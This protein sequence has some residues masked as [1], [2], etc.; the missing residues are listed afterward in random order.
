MVAIS[1][2]TFPTRGPFL[3]DPIVS[4]VKSGKDKKLVYIQGQK[5]A[6]PPLNPQNE[7]V[8][9]LSD[10]STSGCAFLNYPNNNSVNAT[11]NIAH[12]NNGKIR[13]G[14]YRSIYADK[15][16]KEEQKNREPISNGIYGLPKGKGKK[17][18]PS[19]YLR[20][21]D[22]EKIKYHAKTQETSRLFMKPP[23]P[24]EIPIIPKPNNKDYITINA[25]DAIHSTPKNVKPPERYYIN[26]K[27]YGKNPNYLYKRIAEL[28]QQKLEKEK[29]EVRNEFEKNQKRIGHLVCIPS[30]QKES[31]LQGLKDNYQSLHNQY[32]K[33][34]LM[35]D[36]VPKIFKK[37]NMEKQLKQYEKDIQKFEFPNIYVDLSSSQMI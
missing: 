17:E 31:I 19:N 22:G 23:L 7:S 3:R 15:I 5:T 25:L 18:I 16:R 4:E 14:L 9:K 35:A 24:F 21:G 11:N 34:S 1:V 6:L 36:T 20:K 27:D 10:I 37:T 12:K 30:A 32:Q 2:A 29:E 8:Y 26:K 28:E 33:M 13:K